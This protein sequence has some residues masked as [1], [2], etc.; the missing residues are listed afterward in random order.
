MILQYK[1]LKINKDKVSFKK[2][3]QFS[4]DFTFIPM[5]YENKDIIIQT[6]YC[7]VP[8]GL[9]QYSTVST[10]KY[11]DVSF[12]E[13]N[14]HFIQECLSIFF[15]KVSDKYSS[16]YQVEPFLKENQYSKWMR[17]K[18]DEDCLFFDQDKQKIETFTPKIF[19]LF[20]IQLSL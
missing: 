5:L 2:I 14:N 17:F 19:G 12:Q 1:D 10:K 7:F 13:K 9:N 8:F 4:N 15:E 18:V 16:K 20:I 3:K 11:L 6:P